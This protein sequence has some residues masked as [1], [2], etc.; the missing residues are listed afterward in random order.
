MPEP[1]RSYHDGYIFRHEK[2]GDQKLIGKTRVLKGERKN[3]E[4][5][6]LQ[7]SLGK[8]PA[9]GYFIATIRELPV[10]LKADS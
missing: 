6:E 8:L 7:I 10:E 4:K 1:Y 5:F 9:N 3:G 2:F